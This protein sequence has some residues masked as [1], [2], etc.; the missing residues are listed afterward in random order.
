MVSVL[1]MEKVMVIQGRKITPT[2]IS[3]G[4]QSYARNGGLYG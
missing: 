2:D 4:E 1:A 3:E